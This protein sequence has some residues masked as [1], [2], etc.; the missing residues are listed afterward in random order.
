MQNETEKNGDT[1][2]PV[3]VKHGV[4]SISV[5]LLFLISVVQILGVL[6]LFV[7]NFAHI[8]AL[9]NE[10]NDE[11]RVTF[12]NVIFLLFSISGYFKVKISAYVLLLNSKSMKIINTAEYNMKDWILY[13]IKIPFNSILDIVATI[14]I[15]TTILLW[16]WGR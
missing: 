3:Y 5:V 6:G 12:W 4:E 10:V 14:M 13:I 11:V 16:L 9:Y 7:Y 8:L 1:P 15:V 2:D